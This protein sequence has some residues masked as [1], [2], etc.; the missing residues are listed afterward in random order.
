MASNATGGGASP[1]GLSRSVKVSNIEA[2]CALDIA[3]T[4]IL[5]AAVRYLGEP[6]HAG[7]SRGVNTVCERVAGLADRLVEASDAPEH[8]QHEAHEAGLRARGGARRSPI[9]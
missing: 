8:A 5:P 6:V 9:A 4:M 2:S 7:A 1:S 3:R